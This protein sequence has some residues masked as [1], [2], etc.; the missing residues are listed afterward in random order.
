MLAGAVMLWPIIGTGLAG[1]ALLLA[2]IVTAA[3]ALVYAS[4]RAGHLS[5]HLPRC[6]RR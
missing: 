5:P 1:L 6:W 4:V 2:A 3:F